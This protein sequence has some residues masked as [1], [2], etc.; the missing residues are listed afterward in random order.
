MH[1]IEIIKVC[2][3][4][5][6]NILDKYTNKSQ[7]LLS[8]LKITNSGLFGG[9]CLYLIYKT[10]KYKNLWYIND[11]DLVCS[12]ETSNKIIKLLSCEIMK[13]NYFHFHNCKKLLIEL[14][15]NKILDIF[16]FD[17]KEINYNSF[18][19]MNVFEDSLTI[20]ENLL[21]FNNYTI[22][23]KY[24]ND[25]I[26]KNIVYANIWYKDDW[27]N[28]NKCQE[29]NERLKLKFNKLKEQNYYEKYVYRLRQ[30][31]K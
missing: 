3:T 19:S 17:N 27:N 16:I 6:L 21:N 23:I 22:S 11:L 29:V 31:T 20:S 18:S 4:D 25:I 10:L 13:F 26:N 5:I 24:Y 15:N 30:L 8:L 28:F 12:T 7:E 9:T 2:E 14:K 1:K